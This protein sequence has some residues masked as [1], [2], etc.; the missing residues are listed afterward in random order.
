MDAEGHF[1]THGTFVD[2]TRIKTY[3]SLCA[4]AL[5]R[6]GAECGRDDY[7]QAAV[8]SI[9]AAVAQQTA[10]GWFD[11]NCFSRIEAPFVHSIGYTLQ[12]ILEVG[13]LENR[14]DFIDAAR[15]GIDP[16]LR[17]MSRKGYVA[18]RFYSDWRPAL[19]SSCL[20]GSAQL[21][22]VCYQLAGRVREPSYRAAADRL[23]NYLKAL[24]TIDST[25]AAINGALA[26][27]F[28]FFGDYMTAGFPNWATKFFLDAL[29][30]QDQ[31]QEG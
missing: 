16:L 5:Y 28:P 10:N 21:A 15:R 29:M 13:I 12:A 11:N 17:C 4:L 6:F 14:D 1:C 22:V 23:V 9:S 27:S 26:G 7:Q 30:L 24:Q 31:A 19:L 3:N 18:G 2:N 8:R 20:T 25:N